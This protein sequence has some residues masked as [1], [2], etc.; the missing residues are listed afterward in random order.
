MTDQILH[1]PEQTADARMAVEWL[2]HCSDYG[3]LTEPDMVGLT[4]YA[5]LR[6]VIAAHAVPGINF[7]AENIQRQAIGDGAGRPG[8]LGRAN[9]DGGLTDA[10]VADAAGQS[11]GSR[12]PRLCTLVAANVTPDAVDSTS[13]ASFA[14]QV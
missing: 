7:E 2:N 1:H 10:M 3:L 11:S 13:R 12:I 8:V 4:T 9:L 14:M 5:G 6:V